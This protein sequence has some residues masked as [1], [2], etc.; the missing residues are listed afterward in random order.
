MFKEAMTKNLKVTSMEIIANA[1]T[2]CSRFKERGF[3]VG[4]SE[5]DNHLL[6]VDLTN[7]EITG[8]DTEDLLGSVNITVNK[9]SIPNDSQSLVTSGI[10]IGTPA[11]TTRG[12]AEQEAIEVTDLICDAIKNRDN[13]EELERIKNAVVKCVITFL[14]INNV[15]S[16]LLQ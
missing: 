15:L 4:K 7:Q 12:F 1:K 11:M 3:Y 14:C 6:L 13:K 8:K 2:M 5:T 16:F 9:N 10:R